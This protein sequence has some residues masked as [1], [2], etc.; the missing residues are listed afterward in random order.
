[1]TGRAAG[2]NFDAANVIALDELAAESCLIGRRLPSYIEYFFARPQELFRLAMAVEAPFHLQGLS[3]PQKRHAVD[4]AVASCAADAF[5]HVYTVIEVGKVGEIVHPR[6]ADRR[7]V[8]ETV[9]HRFQHIAARPYL[10][11]AVHAGGRGRNAGKSRCF[12]RGVAVAAIDAETGDVMLVAERYRLR[13][14]HIDF[15]D[16][17]GARDG[18]QQP[19]R[20]EHH[21]KQ[22]ENAQTRDGVGAGVKYLRHASHVFY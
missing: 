4:T 7:A 6:P 12:N 18:C 22:T 17:R 15:G 20:A 16:V 9:A 14:R 3:L 19:E 21:K 5:L 8:L 10:R 11:V 13:S 2:Q 1:M